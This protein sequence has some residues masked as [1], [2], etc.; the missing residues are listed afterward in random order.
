MVS[1]SKQ[2]LMGQGFMEDL[3]HHDGVYK[4]CEVRLLRGNYR[5]GAESTGSI[6][7]L[8]AGALRNR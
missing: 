5:Y 2:V 3:L 7:N 1:L 8:M 6:G 4:R